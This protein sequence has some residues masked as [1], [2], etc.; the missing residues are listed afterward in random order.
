MSPKR[1]GSALFDVGWYASGGTLFFLL[2][3]G[4]VRLWSNGVA[5][6]PIL[7]AVA[8]GSVAALGGGLLLAGAGYVLREASDDV[9]AP[10]LATRVATLEAEVTRLRALVKVSAGA[11]DPAP[12]ASLEAARSSAPADR[13]PDDRFRTT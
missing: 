12:F 9:P 7:V 10:D 8:W 1:L 4:G 6:N 5:D 2:V 3:C 11:D 13:P